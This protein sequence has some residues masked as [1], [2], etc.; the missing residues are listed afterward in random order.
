MREGPGYTPFLFGVGFVAA[1]LLLR[2]T[3]PKVL[4]L[5]EPSGKPRLS[6]LL[7]R[8]EAARTARDGIAHVLP[9]NLTGSL[10]RTMILMGAA[11]IAVRAL[12]E[13]VDDD[14]AE[15]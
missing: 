3:D 7:K 11:L 14:G 1:G 2:L 6:G 13:L 10:G 12:D 5:P 4:R 9:R 15:Y 8:D